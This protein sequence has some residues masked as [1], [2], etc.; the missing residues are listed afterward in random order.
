MPFN[1]TLQPV[2]NRGSAPIGFLNQVLV[3]GENE[4]DITFTLRK[5]DAEETDIY[6]VLRKLFSKEDWTSLVRRKCWMMEVLRVL[7]G[8]ESSW[9]PNT[10]ADTTNPAERDAETFSAGLW[11]ISYNSRGFGQ[12]LRDMLVVYGIH[13]GAQFQQMMKTNFTFAA[14]WAARLF[15]HTIRHNG[16]L[17]DHH[18]D[19]YLKVNAVDEWQSLLRA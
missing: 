9:K 13:N 3:W 16:P 5:D 1:H 17:R 18:V 14:R 2:A 10:G 7:A 15:R 8:F 4:P 12:D 11:Q 6:T 19:A